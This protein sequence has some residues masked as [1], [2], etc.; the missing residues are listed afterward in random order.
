[1]KRCMIAGAWLVGVASV[2]GLSAAPARAG[3]FEGVAS[4]FVLSNPTPEMSLEILN[5]YDDQ[6]CGFSLGAS[7]LP[8]GQTE[9]TRFTF[10]QTGGG[11]VGS[12]RIDIHTIVTADLK[13]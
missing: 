12:L 6:R 4:G 2:I 8:L 7:I 3:F 11:V 5:F 10:A 13:F 1:M 9:L